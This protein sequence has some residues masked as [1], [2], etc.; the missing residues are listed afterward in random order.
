M[1]KVLVAR[2]PIYDVEMQLYAYELLYRGGREGSNVNGDQA[3]ADVLVGSLLDIG[4]NNI[5]GR[6][7][8]FVNFTGGMLRE[9]GTFPFPKDRIVVEVLEDITPDPHL[10]ARLR[11]LAAQGHTIALDDFHFGLETRHLLDMAHIVKLD[12]L[13][14]QPDE[15]ARHVADLKHYGVKLLAEKVE[16]AADL[17]RCQQLGFDYYQGYFFARPNVISADAASPNQMAVLQLLAELN[18]TD[19]EMEDLENIIQRDVGLVV[20]VMSYVNSAFF[21][22]ANKLGS[23]KDAVV[24]LGM[25]QIRTLASL[26][27]MATL[28]DKPPELMTTAL[29]RAKLCELLASNNSGRAAG[30][31]VGLFSVLDALLNTPMQSIVSRMHLS[32]EIAAALLYRSG[33]SGQLLERVLAY[34]QGDW[35]AASGAGGNEGELALIA[36]KYLAAL[37]WADQ[38]MV[39]MRGRSH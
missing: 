28:D 11:E 3:T 27:L 9:D 19:V 36:D 12:V 30:F 4:L 24:Y 37:E 38:N 35:G 25:S 22:T 20:K 7:L 15:L 1:H 39:A 18:R 6:H 31:V 2:Q 5:V 21:N 13:N 10:I 17:D 34:E 32:D 33:E 16:T 8:A 26:L 14:Q 23:L 29:V